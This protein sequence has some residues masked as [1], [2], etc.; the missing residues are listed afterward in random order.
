MPD[1][2]KSLEPLHFVEAFPA[3]RARL[4][5]G[6]A[7]ERLTRVLTQKSISERI[8]F[9]VDGEKIL[10]PARVRFLHGTRVPEPRDE[11]GLMVCAIHSRSFDGF[12]RQAAARALLPA[13]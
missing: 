4:A 9:S 3:S 2:L 8:E 7:A 5:A 6:L 12:Q 13:L 11:T 1:M 10:V